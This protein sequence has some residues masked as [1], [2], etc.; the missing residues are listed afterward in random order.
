MI[1]SAAR[2]RSIVESAINMAGP[3]LT[4]IGALWA[5][6]LTTLIPYD[7]PIYVLTLWIAAA[8]VFC[9]VTHET[10]HL[11]AGLIVG[12]PVRKVLIGRGSTVFTARPRGLRIQV[13]ANLV[14]GGAVYFSAIDE[15]SRAANVAVTAAGPAVNIA[16]GLVAL[17]LLHLGWPWLGTLALIA[18]LLGIGNF[19]PS[20]FTTGGREHFS[21]GMLILRLVLGRSMHSTFF[22][23]EDLS[24]AGR[25]VTI[26]AIEEAMDSE[27]ELLTEV[28]LIAALDREPEIHAILL[29][30]AIEQLTRFPGPPTSVDVRPVRSPAVNQIYK[31]TF[32]VARDLG[33]TRPNPACL[34][35]AVMAVPSPLATRLKDAA[36]DT[37]ALEALAKRASAGSPRDQR[38][39]QATALP[40]LPL[41]R[42]GSAADAALALAFQVAIADRADE[43]ATQHVVAAI[44]A[45]RGCRA[46]LALDRAGF[47]LHR[48]DRAVPQTAAP[49]TAPPLTPEAQTAIASAL[50][51]TG[52]DHA[53]GTG[54]LLV[55]L[56]DGERTMA[57][58]LFQ[59]ADLEPPAILA[60]IVG[61]PREASLATG[62]TAAMRRLWELRAGA[63]LAACRY[64]ASRADY[65]VLEQNAPTEHVRA[66]NQ[67]NIAWVS[68][69]SGDVD[70]RGDALER[71]AAAVAALPDQPSLLG[72]HAFALLENGRA[73]EAAAI[74]E[75]VVARQPR[76]RD[77]ALELCLLAMCRTRLGDADAG[78]AHLAAAEAIDPECALLA[79]ARAEIEG[80]PILR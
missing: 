18:L 30:A 45:Q 4:S 59:Q 36:V 21:D 40:D 58:A 11:V 55:G 8:L 50:M 80:S 27:S 54:E 51:R 44:A 70:L 68:L 61:V 15:T 67:N 24:E 47:V 23:G 39:A 53:T 35:L 20:R 66:I 57:A 49:A 76:P 22:E 56:A 52:P 65:L 7:V 42:W 1:Y 16:T 12:R 75:G 14:G 63:R 34:C 62:Y 46:A 37:A 10:G 79:R 17:G 41:E 77:R 74:L 2:R 3:T 33:V 72:T 13:C 69:L 64:A 29:P 25:R 6:L 19:I 71:S 26:R 28:H 60:A 38:P 31:V 78:R 73:A 9:I 5:I 48:N 32:R 43:T